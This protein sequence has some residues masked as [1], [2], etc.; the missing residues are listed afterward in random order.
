MS[1]IKR[2]RSSLQELTGYAMS[3]SRS[4]RNAKS[5]TSSAAWSDG[6][7]IE[8]QIGEVA[9]IRYWHCSKPVPAGWV[10]AA[11]LRGTHHGLRGKV[12]RM[13]K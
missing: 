12:I 9:M 8:M 3:I 10:D 5:P 1:I 4:L 11:N 7:P 2:I 13:V 6:Y